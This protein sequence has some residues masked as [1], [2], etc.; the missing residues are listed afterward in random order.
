VKAPAVLKINLL[1]LFISL[2]IP[3]SSNACSVFSSNI[4]QNGKVVNVLGSR[5]LDFEFS[6]PTPIAKGLQG[7][8]NTSHVN[9]GEIPETQAVTWINEH[10]YVGKLIAPSGEIG[11]GIN[12]KGL[13][14][15]SLYLPGKTIYPEYQPQKDKKALA[16]F[17]IINFT[18][19]TSRNLQEALENL[20]QV[21]IV[22]NALSIGNTFISPELHYFIKDKEGNGAV[23][24]FV[25]GKTVIYT[26]DSIE[27]EINVMTNSPTFDWQ[28]NNYKKM[29]KGFIA[30]NTDYQ[31]DG[32]YANGSGYIG[33]PGD[34]MP[35]SRFVKI[36]AILNAMPKAK[37][38]NQALYLNDQ[39]LSTAII[40]IGLNPAPTLW[41]ST[42]NL[43][44]GD[45]R[46]THLIDI[47]VN[48]QFVLSDRASNVKNYN[49]KTGLD[50]IIIST[51]IS[52]PKRFASPNKVITPAP[53]K[54]GT[55]YDGQFKGIQP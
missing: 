37:D 3:I 14:M 7:V 11:D 28:V 30:K 54:P 38:L 43:A 49:V 13:Y 15:G 36:K 45:Y 9:V 12:D 50:K 34:D 17:D 19:A 41:Y 33:L 24:E 1:T 21:Q 40:P 35:Q 4:Y 18:L 2:L 6:V 29:A 52:Y 20:S 8:E 46:I 32:V 39:A 42:F 10:N 48:G 27:D 53:P 51:K 22:G 31:V 16:V 47:G 26:K 23:I 5:T 55:K 44:D 25:D